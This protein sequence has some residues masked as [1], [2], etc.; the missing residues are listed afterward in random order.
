MQGKEYTRKGPTIPIH[1]NLQGMDLSRKLKSG[2]RKKQYFARKEI[3]K[4][5]K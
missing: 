3:C 5:K 2:I 4:E 1:V